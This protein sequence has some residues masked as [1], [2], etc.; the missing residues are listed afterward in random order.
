MMGKILRL[1][2]FNLKKNKKEAIAITFLTL[3]STMM[4]GIFAV[5]VS[6]ISNAFDESFAQS[7]SVDTVIMI[8]END[9]RDAYQ[10]ILTEGYGFDDVRRGNLLYAMA[11]GVLRDGDK[12]AY[13]LTFITKEENQKIDDGNIIESM[14]EERIE[15]LDHRV[16]LPP[17]FKYNLGYE[18]DD[19]FTVV[20]GGRQY[21]FTVAGFYNT[22]ISNDPGMLFKVVIS[23]EDYRLLTPLYTETVFLSF[24]AGE[25]FDHREYF[26]EC[27]DESGDSFEGNGFTKADEKAN[28]TKFLNMYLYMSIVLSLITFVASIFMVRNKIRSDIEDQMERIGVLEALGYKGNEISL[29]YALEYVV[30]SGIGGIIGGIIAL[31]AAPFMNNIIS[32]MLGREVVS[33]PKVYMIVTVV[34]GVIGLI[35]IF[36]LSK[37]AMVKSF[38]PVTAFR[39]GIRTHSFKRNV[40]PLEKAGNNINIRLGFKDSIRNIRTGAGVGLCIFLAGTAL[41]FCM[42]TFVM[43]FKG[44]DGLVRLMGLEISDDIITINEGVDPYALSEE[45]SGFPEVRKTR[46]SYFYPVFRVEG[47]KEGTVFPY[48]EFTDMEYIIPMDG[49]YPEHDNE[50]MISLRRSREYDLNI[51]DTIFVDHKGVKVN[52]IITGIIG[53]MSNNQMNLYMTNAGFQRANGGASPDMVEIYL[54]D[55]ADREQFEQKLVSVYGQSVDAAMSGDNA[56]GTLEERIQAAAAEKI[57]VLMSTYGVTSVDYAVRVGDRLITGNSRQFVMKELQSYQDLIK[58][59]LDPISDI[60]RAFTGIGAV[61]IGIVVAVILGIIASSDV[62]KR[63]KDLGIMKSL[64]YSSR[65]LMTQIAISIMPVTIVAVVLASVAAVMINKVFWFQLF[66]AD[67][68]TSIPVLILT[69]L[70]LIAFTFVMTYT[71]AGRIRTISVN[72]LMTE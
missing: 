71:G 69:D 11:A 12:I 15:S 44:S 7:G 45:L 38:P 46:V 28:E 62:K 54:K 65:D 3:V 25:G 64:G 6:R 20:A 61:A 68:K 36:A 37:A 24:N 26:T 35:L 60:T 10:D 23:S 41:L 42:F 57:A 40:L 39:K 49:R 43:F 56:G 32:V 58:S 29:S 51:G 21:P 34:I 30:S 31:I 18:I 27:M 47:Q 67:I 5:N 2:L 66:G 22:G 55:G 16:I 53:V 72:E 70:A 59:Q 14:T 52:Y 17:Y 33:S 1:S 48:D 9:Y 63:R 8:P 50:V 19:D 4:L 13:N